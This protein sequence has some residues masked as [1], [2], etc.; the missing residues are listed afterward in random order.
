MKATDRE[1]RVL[2]AGQNDV[3]CSQVTKTLI[4]ARQKSNQLI[5]NFKQTTRYAARRPLRFRWWN[6]LKTI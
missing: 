6:V 3:D 4:T 2:H 1:V 5:C